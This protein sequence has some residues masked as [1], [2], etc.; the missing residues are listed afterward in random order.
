MQIKTAKAAILAQSRQPLVIDEITLPATLGV[1]QVLVRVLY[2]TICGAQLN[3]IAAA[4]GMNEQQF[5]DA[6]A[7]AVKADLDQQVKSGKL[8]QQQEDAILNRVK[9][10]PLPFWNGRPAGPRPAPSASTTTG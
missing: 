8:T 10:G 9:N 3:E 4:K 2:S 6:F 7:A 5:R 1:G